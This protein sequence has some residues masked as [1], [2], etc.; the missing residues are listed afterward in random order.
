MCAALKSMVDSGRVPHALM[1]HEDDGGNA[2]SIA[3]ALLQY[4]YCGNR[5]GEDS[6]GVCPSCNRI[7]K[8]I[9]SD[10]HFVYPTAA[11]DTSLGY[12]KKFRE[13]AC[14]DPHFTEDALSEALGVDSKS[15][16]IAVSEARE[17]LDTL[18][19]GALEGGYRSVVVFYPEYLQTAAANKILKLLE[20]PPAKTLFILITHSPE[21]VLQ[22][23]CSRCQRFRVMPDPK[24][25]ARLEGEM[26]GT[27]ADIFK[28]LMDALTSRD[29]T[30]VLEAGEMMAAL[31]SRENAKAFCKFAGERFRNVFL[32]QQGLESMCDPSGDERRWSA[33]CRKTFPRKACGAVD[34]ASMFIARNVNV[35]IVF[36]DLC[37]RLSNMV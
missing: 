17:M 14:S 10:V 2:F 3:L 33:A 19:L 9:H 1:L 7:S 34:R 15:K 12:V 27:Y 28:R 16:I 4:L 18:S 37:V 11:K 21:K 30:A 31:P 25:P 5:S 35:K 8:L 13:L 20:E 36:T 26:E 23:I 6:C 32:L 22:T 29:L 24:R